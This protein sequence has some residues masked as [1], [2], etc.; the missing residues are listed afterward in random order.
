MISKIA[1]TEIILLQALFN[2]SY[3]DQTSLCTDAKVNKSTGSRALKR[4]RRHNLVSEVVRGKYKQISLNRSKKQEVI[5]L[6]AI[7]NKFTNVLK[8]KSK[9]LIRPHD[10]EA[11]ASCY[12]PKNY[13]R[14]TYEKHRPNNRF[15]IRK[16]IKDVGKAVIT[17]SELDSFNNTVQIFITPFFL[18]VSI[19]SSKEEIDNLIYENINNHSIV[20]YAGF[21]QEVY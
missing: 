4:L 9:V 10:F 18:V 2:Q 20:E 7:W 5:S 12:V 6:L 21:A 11:Y 8:D 13:L 1:E 3:S 14:E 15:C 17:L 16:E 19:D